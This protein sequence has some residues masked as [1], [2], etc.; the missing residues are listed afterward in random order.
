MRPIFFTFFNNS[1]RDRPHTQLLNP[2]R[3]WLGI[4]EDIHQQFGE[5]PRIQKKSKNQSHRHVAL[6]DKNV[7]EDKGRPI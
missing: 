3:F 2:F 7:E 6:I 1:V 5:L 4:C